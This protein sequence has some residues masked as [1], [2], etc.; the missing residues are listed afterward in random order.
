[1]RP[2]LQR[3]ETQLSREKRKKKQ[4]VGYV[5]RSS[6]KLVPCHDTG[7]ISIL[8]MMLSLSEL[9][10]SSFAVRAV[11]GLVRSAWFVQA[12][13]DV[14]MAE[15]KRAGP[16]LTR[17]QK[18]AVDSLLQSFDAASK[19]ELSRSPATTNKGGRVYTYRR[20]RT[21]TLLAVRLYGVEQCGL[22][23]AKTDG[24]T[25]D[26]LEVLV[27]YRAAFDDLMVQG[28]ALCSSIVR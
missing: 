13:I 18:E 14:Q 4:V 20:R 28:Y 12:W 27:L 9:A 16:V 8:L 11:R 10:P 1:M 15:S 6:K 7:G 22:L 26:R 2:Y 19:P 24:S 5:A 23:P 3:Y 17:V 25:D 21:I